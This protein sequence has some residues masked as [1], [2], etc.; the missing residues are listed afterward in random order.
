[1]NEWVSE[2]MQPSPFAINASTKYE[3]MRFQTYYFL[4]VPFFLF[5]VRLVAS[6]FPLLTYLIRA[7]KRRWNTESLKKLRKKET[8]FGM[9]WI[10]DDVLPSSVHSA[11]AFYSVLVG[12]CLLVTGA[13]AHWS[14]VE[15]NLINWIHLFQWL[16][17][18][19]LTISPRNR[20]SV[21]LLR[22]HSIHSTTDASSSIHREKGSMS[23]IRFNLFR[24]FI[25]AT[26]E[27]LNT[28]H[29]AIDERANDTKTSKH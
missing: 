27:Q 19:D 23:E 5:S 1:M 3:Y 15:N 11:F 22:C 28:N 8:Q 16:Y 2:W 17:Q 9:R 7:N 14:R 18:D 21:A 13:R 12:V 26:A 20:L 29:I 10:C 4:L 6:V 25:S 24:S